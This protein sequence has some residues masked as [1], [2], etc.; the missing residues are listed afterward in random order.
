MADQ[1]VAAEELLFDVKV[2]DA[3]K[4]YKFCLI[5]KISTTGNGRKQVYGK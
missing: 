4:L 3:S 1:N 2:A 5:H